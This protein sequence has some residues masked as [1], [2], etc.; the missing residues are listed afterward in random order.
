MPPRL[1]SGAARGRALAAPRRPAR[2]AWG[3]RGEGDRRHGLGARARC[4][5]HSRCVSR[6]TPYGHISPPF[7]P[8]PCRPLALCGGGVVPCGGSAEERVP[9]DRSGQGAAATRGCRGGMPG[10]KSNPAPARRDRELEASHQIN[11]RLAPF[12]FTGRAASKRKRSFKMAKFKADGF[13]RMY[14][15]TTAWHDVGKG[16]ERLTD[17]AWAGMIH[18]LSCRPRAL[19]RPLLAVCGRLRPFGR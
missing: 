1:G 8:F 14:D 5:A 19:G 18:S 6:K 12:F 7:A 9:S 15:A 13:A 4:A 3:S 17:T 2:L 16:R 11:S 10:V